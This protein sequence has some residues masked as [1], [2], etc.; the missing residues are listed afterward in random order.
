MSNELLTSTTAAITGVSADL[1]TVFGAVL[2]VIAVIFGIRKI[3]SM[4]TKS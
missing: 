3:Y 2:G 1:M 4:I